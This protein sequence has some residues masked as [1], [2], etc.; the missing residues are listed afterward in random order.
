MSVK[1]FYNYKSKVEPLRAYVSHGLTFGLGRPSP[2]QGCIE[3]AVCAVLGI[4]HGDSPSCVS[5]IDR[6]LVVGLNDAPWSSNAARAEG[7]VDLGVAHLGSARMTKSKRLKWSIYIAEQG[8]KR[9]GGTAPSFDGLEDQSEWWAVEVS[10]WLVKTA[11]EK[12]RAARSDEPLREA[13][14]IVVE[15]YDLLQNPG[16]RRVLTHD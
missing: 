3:A 8:V 6:G 16:F 7:L 10:N 2:G 9:I 4:P 11:R 1:P 5:Y 12:A 13:A 15:A 14:R